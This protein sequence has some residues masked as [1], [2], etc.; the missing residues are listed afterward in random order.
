MI[1]FCT[2]YVCASKKKFLYSW[3]C[4]SVVEHVLSLCKGLCLIPSIEKK[5]VVS[6]L[7]IVAFL[8]FFFFL[9]VLGLKLRS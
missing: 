9:T 2:K 4:T 1:P 6:N 8:S 7:E 5:I 3:G